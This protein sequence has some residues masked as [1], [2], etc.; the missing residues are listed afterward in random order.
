MIKDAG[1]DPLLEQSLSRKLRI[2]TS[3]KI[4]IYS[5]IDASAVEYTKETQTFVVKFDANLYEPPKSVVRHEKK[6]EEEK[7][8]AS[9]A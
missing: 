8:R 7:R 9:K 3:D 6:L 4:T 2:E 1:G 5:D